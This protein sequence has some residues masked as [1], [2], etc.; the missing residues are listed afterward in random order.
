MK[1]FN[2]TYS[3][4]HLYIIPIVPHCLV[5]GLMVHF[6]ITDKSN[7][8]NDLKENYLNIKLSNVI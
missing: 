3:V 1:C 2:F 7:L 8:G 5:I 4:D 6:S